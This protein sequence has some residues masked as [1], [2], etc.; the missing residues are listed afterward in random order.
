[1]YDNAGN[2]YESTIRKWVH[3]PLPEEDRFLVVLEN[4]TSLL[5]DG[6]ATH[7]DTAI[8]YTYDA[9]GNVVQEKMW[10]E[11]NANG[12]NGEF[13]DSGSDSRTQSYAYIYNT[14]KNIL[15]AVKEATLADADGVVVSKERAFYDNLEWGIVTKGNLTKAEKWLNTTDEY[16]STTY[17]YSPKGLV[18]TQTTPRGHTTTYSYDSFE[19]Y[20]TIISN[21]LGHTSTLTYNYAVGDVKRVVDPNGM[22]QVYVYDGIGRVTS[23][24]ISSNTDADTLVTKEQTEYYDSLIPRRVVA[25]VY[26]SEGNEPKKSFTYFDG[27]GRIIQTRV[28]SE[29]VNRFSVASIVYDA[30]GRVN[31]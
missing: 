4:E 12:A 5:W 24:K 30:L 14:Q 17:T 11:V 7:R 29:E 28:S 6:N 2:V 18:R 26:H 8:S 31:K 27:F 3:S 15:A 22:V 21:A 9:Y 23:R 19:L 1:M 20:P 13:A 10:G 25:S 16:I